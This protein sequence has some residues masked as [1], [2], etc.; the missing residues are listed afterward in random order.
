M[1]KIWAVLGIWFCIWFLFRL[2]GWSFG[3]A[4]NDWIWTL[5]YLFLTAF[6]ITRYN[7]VKKE[8]R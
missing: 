6:C 5:V 1:Y 8:V 7:I 2:V 4:D 3:W